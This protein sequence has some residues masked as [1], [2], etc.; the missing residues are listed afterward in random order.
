MK[1]RVNNRKVGDYSHYTLQ[2]RDDS[3]DKQIIGDFDV[4]FVILTPFSERIL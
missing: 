3:V 2:S 4:Y 1:Y